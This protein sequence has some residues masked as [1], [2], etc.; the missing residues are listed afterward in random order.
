[1]PTTTRDTQSGIEDHTEDPT[2]N[3]TEDLT[4]VT[5]GGIGR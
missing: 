4:A 1:M 5:D 2:E 3:L